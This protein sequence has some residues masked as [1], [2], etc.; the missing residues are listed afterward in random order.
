MAFSE[1]LNKSSQ[2]ENIK[3]PLYK[4]QNNL[5]SNKI[6]SLKATVLNKLSNHS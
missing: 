3:Q 4:L 6:H 2:G 5:I 1:G